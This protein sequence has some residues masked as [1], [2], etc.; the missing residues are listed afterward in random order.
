MLIK[1][2]YAFK[3][4]ITA[5]SRLNLILTVTVSIFEIHN[6]K[7]MKYGFDGVKIQKHN[8][9]YETHDSTQK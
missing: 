8:V 6:I 2:Y 7:F 9:F 5:H 4:S 1:V 3:I